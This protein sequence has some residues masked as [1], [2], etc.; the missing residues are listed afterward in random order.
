VGLDSE[1]G[2]LE[3]GLS[4][5]LRRKLNE[6]VVEIPADFIELSGHEVQDLV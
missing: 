3:P 5:V 4:D 1:L 2:G 6:V